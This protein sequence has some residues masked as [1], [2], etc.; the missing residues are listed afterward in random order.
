[1]VLHDTLQLGDQESQGVVGGGAAGVAAQG[2][3]D[4]Y[5]DHANVVTLTYLDHGGLGVSFCHNG[6]FLLL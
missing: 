1:M 5:D 2:K 3:G 4:G 6:S